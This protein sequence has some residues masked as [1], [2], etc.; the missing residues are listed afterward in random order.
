MG[1]KSAIIVVCLAVVSVALEVAAML[2]PMYA[3]SYSTGLGLLELFNMQTYLVGVSAKPSTKFCAHAAKTCASMSKTH[4]LQAMSQWF[5][6]TNS[7]SYV[8]PGMCRLLS[9]SH[10]TGLAVTVACGLNM[11]LLLTASYLVFDYSLRSHKKQYRTVALL[12]VGLGTACLVATLLVYA[13]FPLRALRDLE[14]PSGLMSS[15]TQLVIS[16]GNGGS[17]SIGYYIAWISVLVQII[18]MALFSAV[19]SGDELD[20][21]ALQELKQKQAFEASLVAQ[22]AGEAWSYDQGTPGSFSAQGPYGVQGHPVAPGHD[23]NFATSYGA[24][25]VG[26]PVSFQGLLPPEPLIGF[27][28]APMTPGPAMM[29]GPLTPQS[30]APQMQGQA[31]W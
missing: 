9:L 16:A 12:L 21:A 23:Q 28:G 8:F 5:C 27:Q 4:D 7:V 24:V 31:G 14:L 29:P 20:E 2:L 1:Q 10:T 3:V 18:M 22:R 15:V 17:I 6:A 30:S 26:P 19:R 25:A 11:A 13:L